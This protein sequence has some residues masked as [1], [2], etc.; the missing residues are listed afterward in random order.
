MSYATALANLAALS[1]P[2]VA[3]NYAPTAIPDRLSRALLPALLVLPLLEDLDHQRVSTFQLQTPS[4]SSA[5]VGYFCT[6]LLLY[7]ALGSGFGAAD[8]TAGL[9]ALLDSYAAAVRADPRLGGT[10]AKP[11]EYIVLPGPLRWG[12]GR[13]MGARI[14]HRLQ[15]VY[16]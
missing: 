5:A 11:S 9:T 1:V 16:P 2:G 4:G 7:T 8:W 3:H 6:H 15:V 12:G 13:Y 14:Q 10:L